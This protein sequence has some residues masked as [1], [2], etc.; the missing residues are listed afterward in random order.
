MLGIDTN[1]LE[2]IYMKAK[3]SVRDFAYSSLFPRMLRGEKDRE[4]KR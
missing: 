1:H 2:N 3:P 4:M